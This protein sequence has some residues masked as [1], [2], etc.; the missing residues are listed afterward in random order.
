MIWGM[1]MK[2]T[3]FEALPN[4]GM[5]RQVISDS[6]NSMNALFSTLSADFTKKFRQYQIQL[7]EAENAKVRN[8]SDI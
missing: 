7:G 1:Q 3:Q 4:S 2:C 6:W 5:Q 8:L